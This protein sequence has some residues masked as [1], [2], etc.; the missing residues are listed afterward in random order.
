[1]TKV[2]MY[3]LGQF[4]LLCSSAVASDHCAHCSL[5]IIVTSLGV[6]Y[7]LVH[8]LSVVN[9]EIFSATHALELLPR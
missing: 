4:S 2:Y 7:L 3:V 8:V 5:L 1:M 9:V 6:F